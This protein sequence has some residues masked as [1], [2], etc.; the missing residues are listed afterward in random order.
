MRI[1]ITCGAC[2]RD[3]SAPDT[4]VGRKVVCPG[5]GQGV[6]VKNSGIASNDGD[7]DDARPTR[8]ARGGGTSVNPKVLMGI[9]GVI[10]AVVVA[11][12][13]VN[14]LPSLADM[15]SMIVTPPPANPP[16]PANNNNNNNVVQADESKSAPVDEAIPSGAIRPPEGELEAQ[17]KAQ[18]LMNQPPANVPRPEQGAFPGAPGPDRSQA[19]DESDTERGRRLL[20]QVKDVVLVRVGNKN[21]QS[22]DPRGTIWKKVSDRS[23]T[24]A[25]KL[26]L[27]FGSGSPGRNSAVLQIEMT[28][29]P[30]PVGAAGTQEVSLAAELICVDPKAKGKSSR[31]ATVWKHEDSVGTI[32]RTALRSGKVPEKMDKGIADFVS[33]FRVAYQQAAKAATSSDSEPDEA[34][35][36]EEVMEGDDSAEEPS[37]EA[38]EKTES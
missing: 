14:K 13:A 23:K 16:P 9:F 6:K 5:C 28:G 31:Y 37:T 30:S 8:R 38:A 25:E 3:F 1:P 26:G 22:Y 10:A 18:E 21:G 32:A 29:K 27:K 11:G 7:S 4:H 17:R 20:A 19:A 35:E 15:N 2:G 36:A 12:M 34:M 33:R 24:T